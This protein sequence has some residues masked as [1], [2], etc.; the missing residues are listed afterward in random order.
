[1]VA[2]D[3]R[4]LPPGAIESRAALLKIIVPEIIDRSS[5]Y[6][7]QEYSRFALL[8]TCITFIDVD[9]LDAP[10]GE[11]NRL[12]KVGFF[13]WAEATREFDSAANLAVQGS[14]KAAIDHIRRA[15]E[16]IAVG[17]YF[18]E[19]SIDISDARQWMHSKADTPSFRRLLNT[20][21][22][23]E[24]GDALSRTYPWR[25]EVQNFYW[26]LCDIVHVKGLRHSSYEIQ[27]SIFIIG[28][29]SVLRFNKKSLNYVWDAF[30]KATQYSALILALTNPVLL[31]GLPIDEKFGLNDPIS[32]YFY[33][34]QAE[35]LNALLPEKSKAFFEWVKSEHPN[36]TEVVAWFESMPDVT[37]EV[38]AKQAKD[39][40]DVLN[41]QNP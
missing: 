32:G 25:E 14:Y 39:L 9:L 8:D 40:N 7:T 3:P 35:R 27:P 41:S 24:L 13:P 10:M 34:P 16:L 12:Q 36:V 1:M 19:E 20:L 28:G 26:S 5:S 21:A 38:L 22:K 29:K 18:T 37:E 33:A 6:T 4:D 15:L 30:I 17:G 23:S 11:V 31:I 2:F